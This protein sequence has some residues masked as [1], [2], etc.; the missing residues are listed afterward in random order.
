MIRSYFLSPLWRKLRPSSRWAETRPSP[1]GRSGCA[2]LPISRI[3]E[4]GKAA[5]P[6]RPYGDGRVSAHLDDG[7][8]FLHKGERK[9]DLIIFALVD[10]LVLHSGYSSLR[11]ESFLFSEQA[12]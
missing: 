8:S 12:F 3:L 9:Y 4:I 11:L 5:H 2:A 1:Y 6:D 10:S 7:R